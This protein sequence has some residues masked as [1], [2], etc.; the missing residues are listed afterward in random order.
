MLEKCLFGLS[1]KS[2]KE[3]KM[4][5]KTSWNLWNIEWAEL[6]SIWRIFWKVLISCKFEIFFHQELVE[7]PG[8]WKIW[9]WN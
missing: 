9:L 6:P 1:F 4:L 3:E 8:I 5:K 2:F 7:T